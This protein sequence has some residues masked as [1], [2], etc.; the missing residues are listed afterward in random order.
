M[1][2]PNKEKERL[3]LAANGNK[4]SIPG[5]MSPMQEFNQPGSL[6]SIQSNTNSIFKEKDIANPIT[7][8]GNIEMLN[9]KN[10]INQRKENKSK[11]SDGVKP[12]EFDSGL[13]VSLNFN[14]QT[15]NQSNSM[16]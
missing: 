13:G 2:D 7:N 9:Q 12:L 14:S 3:N 1:F 15:D 8:I 4:I 6:G 11:F 5:I 16:F 10:L